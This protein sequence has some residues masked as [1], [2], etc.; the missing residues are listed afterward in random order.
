MNQS[1][2]IFL[3][4]I[5]GIGAGFFINLLVPD[6]MIQFL[7][8][9]IL[10]LVGVG[11]IKLIQFIVVPLVLVSL[12]TSMSSL[13]DIKKIGR[14]SIKLLFLYIFTSIISLI[15]GL[16]V[17]YV[18]KPGIGVE[19]L[20]Q[21]VEGKQGL[22]LSEWLLSIIPSNPFE[23][24]S[25]GHMVQIIITALLLGLGVTLAG[26][27]GKPFSVFIDS[28]NEVI[29]KIMGIIL[30]LAPIGVFSLMASVIATQGLG[31]I[32]SL[33]LYV[34]GLIIAILLMA[35]GI[36]SI[37]LIVTGQNPIKFW[38]AFYPA[39]G[40]AFGT[41]SS[42]ATLPLAMDNAEHRYGMKKEL[43]SF[44]IPFGVSLKKDGAAILQGFTAVFVSQM[45]G[46]NLSINQ[47]I[48]VFVSAILVSL[49]TAGVPGAGI[50]MMSTVLSAAN[51]PLEAI[52]II[53]GV[54]RLTDTFRTALN[55][56]GVVA[57]AAI[58]EKWER[59]TT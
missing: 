52:A 7:D 59:R 17:A 53:A 2:K 13:G 57:N 56:I 1:T 18:L 12:V 19:M 39:F 30:R 8:K 9:N 11:F 41:A 27:K 26:E 37:L 21:K 10:H 49:S 33:S 6:E 35:F 22:P 31:I 28:A 51:L 14:Y 23:S 36:Y 32:K 54:D 16:I 25:T 15:I 47:I 20:Q 38:K 55:V 3:A 34:I 50:I 4:M 58:L 40:L 29:F 46:A 48:A 24:M 43:V 42:N 5:L 44:A 45:I